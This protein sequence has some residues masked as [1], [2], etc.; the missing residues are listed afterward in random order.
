[1]IN[2]VILDGNE[3]GRIGLETV[4][5]SRRDVMRLASCS[6]FEEF[7]NLTS[8]HQFDVVLLDYSS[9]GFSIS[10][11]SK[12]K[13]LMPSV[14]IVAITAQQ[15]VI[16]IQHALQ[17]GI[18]GYVK[19][20]CSAQEIYDSVVASSAGNPFFCGEI[21]KLLEDSG[22]PIEKLT[23]GQDSCDPVMISK[24]ELEIIQLIASGY[25]NPQIAKQLFLSN[26]TVNAHKKNIFSKLGVNHTTGVVMYA[27][28]NQII[29]PDEFVFTT[30]IN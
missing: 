29:N 20:S 23:E 28:K 8:C 19:K 24:R 4:F 3:L 6:N 25:S 27:V 15:N 11:V 30:D 5:N 12:I 14:Q 17:A 10:S 21:V 18:I 9:K 13:K 26:H 16:S 7:E 1:M 22:I 2:L